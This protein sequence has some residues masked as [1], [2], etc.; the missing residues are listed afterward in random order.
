MKPLVALADRASL[1]A[2]KLL[3]ALNGL[4]FLAFLA[5]LLVAL[6]RI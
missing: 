5:G 1:P 6:G 4:A 2:L 3:V